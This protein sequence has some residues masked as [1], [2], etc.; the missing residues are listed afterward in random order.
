MFSSQN[1]EILQN[2]FAFDKI[3]FTICKVQRQNMFPVS[4]EQNEVL[5]QNKKAFFSSFKSA[6]LDIQNKIVKM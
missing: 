1:Y 3:H 4:Q 2:H 6:L 5:K